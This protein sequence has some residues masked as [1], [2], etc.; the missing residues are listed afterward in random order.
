M[1]LAQ[2]ASSIYVDVINKKKIVPSAQ[3][4]Y[5]CRVWDVDVIYAVKITC[6]FK[7][8]ERF[9]CQNYMLFDI[10]FYE[11]WKQDLS[12]CECVCV[13]THAFEEHKQELD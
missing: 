11:Y 3:S 5:F 2:H 6:L 8:K 1:V 13:C 10:L 7:V 9:H 12:L 4:P